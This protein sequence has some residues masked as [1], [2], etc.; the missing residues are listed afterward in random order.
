[1]EPGDCA[2]LSDGYLIFHRNLCIGSEDEFMRVLKATQ[3]IVKTIPVLVNYNCL[4]LKEKFL[5]Q[6]Y[7]HNQL[8]CKIR[9]LF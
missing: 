1:M 8:L 5:K 3:I 4:E 6:V 2:N 9:T 7:I